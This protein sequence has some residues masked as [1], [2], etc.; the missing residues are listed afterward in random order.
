MNVWRRF[1]YL[2]STMANWP[3]VVPDKLGLLR[4]CR[5]RTRSG[6]TVSCRAR[7]SDVNE[8]VVVLSGLEYPARFLR[9][10]NGSVVV[11]LGANI[12]SF[13]LYVA[14][15]NRGVSLRGVAFEPFGQSFTLLERNLRANGISSFRA[16]QAAVTDIDGWIRLRTD[17]GVDRVSVAGLAADGD[18]ADARSYRLSTY[19]AAH[20][21]ASIDLLKMDVEGA[22]HDIVKADYPFIRTAVTSALIEYHE[23][24]GR[25]SFERLAETLGAD[26]DVTVVHPGRASGVIHAR[27]RSLRCT[28]LP[29][30]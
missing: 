2:R 18:R 20:G 30:A 15:L 1:S 8:A 3:L 28:G 14:E 7:S 13:A 5:Y 4:T 25:R 19:C 29:D 23:G 26:F 10:H 27:N 24:G 17:C 11:D 16:V 12:G 22:E 6:V 9:L 21:I